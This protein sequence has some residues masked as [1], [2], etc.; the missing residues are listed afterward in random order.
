M[1]IGHGFD[2]HRFVD[3]GKLIIGGVEIPYEKGILAHSDGDVLIHA[4]IDALLGAAGK[5]DIGNLFPDSSDEFRN[6]DSRILLRK[7]KG[8]LDG[9]QLRIVNLDT[10]IVA[11]APKMG[12][13]IEAMRKNLVQDLNMSIDSINI[14][15]TT[16]EGMGFT[17]RSEGLAAFAIVL[18]DSAE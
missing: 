17:G 13:H 15:A 12:P 11:Q 16:T 4:L 1:K 7:V 6:I 5:G 3:E 2:A 8:V 10:T 18:L 14:K 9:C